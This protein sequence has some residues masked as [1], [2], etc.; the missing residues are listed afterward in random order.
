MPAAA[1][2]AGVFSVVSTG[3][4][5]TGH[6]LASGH[7]VPWPGTGIALVLLFLLAVP[8]ARGPSSLPT[9]MVATGAAQ[10]A[11]HHWLTRSDAHSA[12]APHSMDRHDVSGGVHEAWHAGH[13]GVSMTAAHIAAALLVAWCL[14]RADT[15]C[16]ALG[17]LGERAGKVI[18]GF[19]VRLVPA[20][21]PFAA[22]RVLRPAGAWAQPPPSNSLVLAHAVVRRG[23]PAG[24]VPAV[25]QYDLG[26]RLGVPATPLPHR[27]HQCPVPTGCRAPCS[28][29]PPSPSSP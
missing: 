7:P 1:A 26:A 13:H 4:G 3:L 19:L 14:Q 17:E 21:P 2:R 11:L 16:R 18:V 15:A 12:R 29:C 24:A 28:G 8:V 5:L 6:H 23:P 10:A 9:A 22:P 25:Q 20:V 27:S